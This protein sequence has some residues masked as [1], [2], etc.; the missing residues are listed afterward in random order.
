MMTSLSSGKLGAS[1]KILPLD[2]TPIIEG[3]IAQKGRLPVE[4]TITEAPA[5][6]LFSSIERYLGARS[7]SV[8]GL[9]L[10]HQLSWFTVGE[11]KVELLESVVG[12]DVVIMPTYNQA[13]FADNPMAASMLRAFWLKNYVLTSQFAGGVAEASGA[14]GRVHLFAP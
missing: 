14:K 1:V 4:A 3:L 2:L 11:A 9:F 5:D 6:S 10:P 8:E 13:A 12:A 7:E